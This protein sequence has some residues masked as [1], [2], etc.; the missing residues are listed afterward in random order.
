MMNCVGCW[1]CH[2]VNNWTHHQVKQGY[3]SIWLCYSM[4]APHWYADLHKEAD[5]T[6]IVHEPCSFMVH[7][8]VVHLSGGRIAGEGIRGRCLWEGQG[9]GKPKQRKENVVGFCACLLP[10]EQLIE[11][12]GRVMLEELCLQDASEHWWFIMGSAGD[13]Q[14]SCTEGNV[15]ELRVRLEQSFSMNKS[16]PIYCCSLGTGWCS[17]LGNTLCSA[18]SYQGL[19]KSQNQTRLAVYYFLIRANI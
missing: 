7:H 3:F 19:W 11:G 2:L 10:E 5:V 18:L 9:G 4:G 17:M 13:S 12:K 15:K 14:G 6:L 1:R 16:A 8:T